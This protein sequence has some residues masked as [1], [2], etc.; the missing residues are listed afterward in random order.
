MP[1]STGRA[2]QCPGLPTSAVP[3]IPCLILLANQQR[4]KFALVLQRFGRHHL[5]G[6]LRLVNDASD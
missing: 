3:I 5:S 1:V 6:P 4:G 2:A